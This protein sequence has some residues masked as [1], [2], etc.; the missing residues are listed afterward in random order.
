MHKD[1]IRELADWNRLP[2]AGQIEYVKDLHWDFVGV[3]GVCRIL[4]RKYGTSQNMTTVL[5]KEEGLKIWVLD[6]SS[7]LFCLESLPHYVPAH[8]PDFG[9]TQHS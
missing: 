4:V 8:A 2:Q 1:T 5:N 6:G 9:R 7:T 3:E